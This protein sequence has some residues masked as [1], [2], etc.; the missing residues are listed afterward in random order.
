MLMLHQ[1]ACKSSKIITYLA[2]QTVS[3][4]ILELLSWHKNPVGFLSGE[5]EARGMLPS[6]LAFKNTS[7][8][9]NYFAIWIWLV[10]KP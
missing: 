8:P 4:I 2:A 7:S 5:S 9:P 1:S 6:R 3:I 10:D